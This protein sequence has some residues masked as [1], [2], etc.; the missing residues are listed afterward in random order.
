MTGRSG[1][2]LIIWSSGA[3]LLIVALA[4]VL[5]SPSP[6]DSFRYRGY[7]PGLTI[8][9][10]ILFLASCMLQYGISLYGMSGFSIPL[11]VPVI[12]I[13]GYWTGRMDRAE[14]PVHEQD[15]SAE[16]D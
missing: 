12:L 2:S 4:L 7:A 14:V 6:H 11:G 3:V 16:E 9:A 8:C 5:F 1:A 13:I 15:V 10:G